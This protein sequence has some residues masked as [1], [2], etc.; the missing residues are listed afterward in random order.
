LRAATLTDQEKSV[1]YLP[2]LLITKGPQA[3]ASILLDFKSLEITPL[4]LGRLA[5]ECD[6]VLQ[7]FQNK[8]SRKHARFSY[9]TEDQLVILTDAGSSNGTQVNGE[10]IA[11]ATA[12]FPGDTIACG[13]VEL[14]FVIPIPQMGLPLAK[15]PGQ[16]ERKYL[17]DSEPGVA[18]LEI[19]TSHAAAVRPG[20]FC[21]LTPGH[22]F[23]VGRFSS[24]DLPLLEEGEKARLVSRRHAEIRW[25]S[26]GYIIRDLGAANPAWVNQSRLEAPRLLEDGDA[27]QVGSTL[28]RYRAPRLPLS[29]TSTTAGAGQSRTFLLKVPPS[30]SLLS[31]PRMLSLPTNRQILIGRAEGNDMRL[32]DRSISRRHVRL[33]Y[34]AR[35]FFLSD[36]GS[37]NGTRLNGREVTEPVVLQSGDRL[38]FGNFEF[39]LQEETTGSEA[40]S[41]SLPLPLVE[42][43]V[44]R[45]AATEAPKE[46]AYDPDGEVAETVRPSFH[47]DTAT[48]PPITH[49]L[50]NITP[51]DELDSRSFMLLTPHFK[52]V[53]Y[54]PGQEI[55]REGQEK[56]AFLAI[57]EGRVTVS[58]ALNDK[59]RLVVGE[60]TAGSVFGERTVMENLAFANRLEAV[61]P[62]RAL[63]LEE[64]VYKREFSHNRAI[65]TFFQQQVSAASATNWLRATLLM[66]TLSEKTRHAMAH[67]LRYRVYNPG[68]TLAELGQPAEEFFLMLAGVAVAYV[69]DTRGGESP[70]ATLEEGDTFGDGIVAPGETYPMTVRAEGKVACYVLARPDFENVLAKSGDP[71]ASLGAGL[72]GLPLGAV[73]N[74]VGPFQQ[75]PPQLVTKIAAE[76]K[77]KFFK[78]G[79]TIVQ[80][81]EP[82]SAFYVIRS[83]KVEVSFRTSG[84]EVRSDMRLGPGQYFGEVSLLTNTARADTVKAVEDCEL[85]A[86]Y[87]N[88]LE[89]VLKLG[90]SYDLGQYFA[91]SLT[92]R[93]RPKRIARV[94]VSQ[95]TNTTG[96]VYYLLSRDGGEQ[97]FKLSDRS[98]FL[99]NLMDGDNSLNDLSMAFF[100]EYKKLDLEGVS[101]L[102][103]QLQAASFLEIPA[104]DEKFVDPKEGKRSHGPLWRVFNW[105]YE[106]KHI[107]RFFGRLY[108]FG[109]KILFWPPVAGLL[110]AVM[111][112]G[113]GAFL[114]LGLFSPAASELGV[115]R[116]FQGG[117][118]GALTAPGALPWWAL[119]LVLLF[120]FIIHETAHGLACKAYGRRVI[121]G[122]FGLQLGWPFFFV[123]TNEIW[124][125]KRRPRIVVNLAG[126]AS[127]ALL[128]GMCCLALLFT[129]DPALR[130]AL[131][132][133]A[134]IA[135]VLVYINVNPL[136]E[137]DG[138]FALMDWLEI[139]GL[140]RKALTYVRRRILRRPQPGPIS[141]RERRIFAWYALLTPL[142]ILFTMFQFSF[143]LDSL[144]GAP[145]MEG[146]KWLGVDRSIGDGLIWVL[147][148]AIAALLAWPYFAEIL[149]IGRDEEEMAGPKARRRKIR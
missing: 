112:A 10:Y 135:Y 25:S 13:D 101:N 66:R 92:K 54:K 48:S 50:R 59:Q 52:E 96:E 39:V 85:L 132:Q 103:G 94:Q 4:T 69:S 17:E 53:T 141:K 7:S 34:E 116:I 8:V 75:L 79:E 93:S 26:S 24:S 1:S 12:L 32:L 3:G 128:A 61:T 121:S 144:V 21:R 77:P 35:H 70:L 149:T 131:F 84:G 15:L 14:V 45:L 51:F 78:Q 129:G 60:L 118:L 109:G 44:Y 74:R 2:H 76:M 56:G 111:L 38:Q 105:R 139:P 65:Q 63:R 117:G 57:L 36:L 133:A 5:G 147:A 148:L 55:V 138:Y 42:P 136:M 142:Y 140:R 83:G 6:F 19:V 100:L 107:D 86:L 31:G 47:Q 115:V 22:P 37:A 108:N 143:F 23:L 82:A 125:E 99:W 68:E 28:L 30:Q 127:N 102:V 11:G 120:N 71:V 9:R 123:N 16:T 97:F 137:L 145:L 62:V 73:L 114:Y 124:L 29:D 98:L 90:E 81:N 67:R 126:P 33:F 49:P 87:R 106:F 58:R 72:G 64:N 41:N 119:L 80:Q 95:Q 91:K 27:V 134:A 122:G 46:A 130:A 146:L 104:I 110:V 18:R 20:S 113:L 40:S 43:V 89:G 88:K